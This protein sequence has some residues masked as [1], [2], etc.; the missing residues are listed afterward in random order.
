MNHH[1]VGRGRGGR[2]EALARITAPTVVGGID[3]DRLY[4]PYLQE[5]LTELIPG[6][7]GP[8]LLRSPHGHEA[9]LIES[10]Q[11]AD[12]VKRTLAR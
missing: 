12:L 8:H 7:D 1:D 4:P 9:F 5:E 3:S 6:A 10:D 2:A 11:V